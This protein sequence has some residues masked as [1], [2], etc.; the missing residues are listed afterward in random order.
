MK[1]LQKILIT[2]VVVMNL[3]LQ[4]IQIKAQGSEITFENLTTGSNIKEVKS[5]PK[6]SLI[7]N[8]QIKDIKTFQDNNLLKLNNKSKKESKKLYISLGSGISFARLYSSQKGGIN[9]QFNVIKIMSSTHAIRGDIQFSHNPSNN[10]NN[11]S[12]GSNEGGSYN[13]YAAKFDFLLGK[14]RSDSEING[15]WILGGGLN[16]F[17]QTDTKYTYKEFDHSTMSYTGKTITYTAEHKA[18]KFINLEFGGGLRIKVSEKV[19]L[20]GEAQYS[21]PLIHMGSYGGIGWIG[22]FLGTP[23]LKIGAQIEL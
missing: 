6:D 21:F 15:Y 11:Y 3:S 20:Y 14:F 7:P 18:E 19:N 1:T 22:L 5:Q 17:K 9:L 23:T 10:N 16:V 13:N 4:S 2:M 8:D 12:Y